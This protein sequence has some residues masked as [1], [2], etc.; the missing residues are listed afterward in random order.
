MRIQPGSTI[1]EW[2]FCEEIGRGAVGVIFRARHRLDGRDYAIKILRPELSKLDELKTRFL[3]EAAICARLEHPNIVKT[4]PAFEQAGRLFLPMELLEGNSLAALIAL[5]EHPWPVDYIRFVL[6]QVSSALSYAH[7]REVAHRDVKLG[8]IFVLSDGQTVKLV[9]FGLAL[10]EDSEKLTITGTTVGTPTYLAPEIIDGER[11]S[12]A[13]DIYALGIVLYRLLTKKLPYKLEPV[14]NPLLSAIEMR[15][16]QEKGLPSPAVERPDCPSDIVNLVNSMIAFEPE[17][18]PASM[19]EVR[20]RLAAPNKIN[21]LD[22]FRKIHPPRAPSASVGHQIPA[23]NREE[24]TVGGRPL[25][26]NPAAVSAV[27]TIAEDDDVQHPE[28]DFSGVT[29]NIRVRTDPTIRDFRYSEL[30]DLE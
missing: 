26:G 7:S 6:S 9:D 14:A 28:G 5:D 15:I 3:Q 25:Q 10:G 21:P 18:R 11:G 19:D 29:K 13:G 2:D 8:N 20:E 30:K 1:R 17:K 27:D 16:Q 23:N 12:P 4:L 24:A 22:L